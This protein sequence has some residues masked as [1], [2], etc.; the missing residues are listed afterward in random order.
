MKRRKLK[1]SFT[2]EAAFLFTII[3]LLTAFFLQTAISL[4]GTVDNAAVIGEEL[5]EIDGVELF[6]DAAKLNELIKEKVYEN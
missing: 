5:K 3:V 1:G 6:L 2:V 4:Y